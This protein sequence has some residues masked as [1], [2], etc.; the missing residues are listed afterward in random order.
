[1]LAIGAFVIVG[2]AAEIPARGVPAGCDGGVMSEKYWQ[3][4][5][6]DEH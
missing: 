4:W 6:A 5:N 2:N 1:M 3:I